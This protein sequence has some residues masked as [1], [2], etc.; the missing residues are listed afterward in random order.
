MPERGGLRGPLEA[1]YV[2]I[3]YVVG[4]QGGR[5]RVGTRMRMPPL[6]LHRW[7]RVEYERLVDKGVFGPDDRIELLDGLLVVREPQGSLHAAVVSQVR[8]VLQDA[9]GPRWDVRVGAPIALDD[10]S[11][12]EPDLAV[13][14]GRPRDYRR[15]HPSEPMLIV[16]VSETSLAKDRLRKSGLYARAG[17]AEYW[18]VNL[19]DTVL[20]VYREPVRAPSR[21][22]GW[23]YASLRLL[24]RNAVVSPL[25]APRARIRV[26]DLLP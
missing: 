14:R 18:I 19:V 12:P 20:E 17:R 11:E 16:E 10:T 21:R 4:G 13:V 1:P 25:A 3:G 22:Y 26:V 9:F 5:Y 2:L 15:Q 6:K 8:R 23:K 7:K 24:K